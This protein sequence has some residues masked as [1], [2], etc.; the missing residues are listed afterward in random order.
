MAAAEEHVHHLTRRNE[1]LQQKIEKLKAKGSKAAQHGVET[2]EICAGAAIGGL[3][4]GMAKDQD[5]GPHIFHVPADLALGLAGLGLGA[6]DV[7]GDSSRDVA[8]LGKGFLAAY[9]TDF[10]HSIGQR[11]RLSGSYFPKKGAPAAIAAGD[12]QAMADA[13]L[14]QMQR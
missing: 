11:K 6:F 10:G 2:L 7:A 9:A 4:Q 13:V 12:P 8:N 14:Q 1:S 5:H 3:L